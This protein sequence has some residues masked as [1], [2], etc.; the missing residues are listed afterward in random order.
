MSYGR[1]FPPPCSSCLAS[2]PIASR[3]TSDLV[4]RLLR[5]RRPIND[6]VFASSRTLKDISVNPPCHTQVYYSSLMATQPIYSWSWDEF[7]A[8]I[9]SRP[10][11]GNGGQQARYKG[12][13]IL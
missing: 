6:S 7:V 8:I 9:A 10:A 4:W 11:L 2:A 12:K 13:Q 1:F 5:A 3:M